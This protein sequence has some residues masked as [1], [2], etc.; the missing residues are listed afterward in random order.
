MKIRGLALENFRKFRAPVRLSGFTDGLN[1]ICEANE[2]GKSTLLEAMRAALFERHGAKSE[3]VRSFRPWGDE[4]APAVELTFELRGEP[5]VIRK[6]FLQA[7]RAVLVGPSGQTFSSD[8]AEERLQALLGFERSGK[9]G[10]DAESR[11]VLGMLWIEQGDALRIMVPGRLA[12]ETIESVLAGE[13]GAVTGG[14]RATAVTLAVEGALKELRTLGTGQ[15]TGR[16]LEAQK[17]LEAARALLTDA[18]AISRSFGESLDRLQTVRGELVRLERDLTA[19]EHATESKR[20]QQDLEIARAA[21]GRL[22][23]AKA[24]L[25]EATSRREG[26]ER[27]LAEREGL[28]REQQAADDAVKA[29]EAAVEDHAPAFQRALAQEADLA[30]ALVDLRADLQRAEADATKAQGAERAT[31]ERL[32]IAKAFERLDGAEGLVERLAALRSELDQGGMSQEQL[33]SPVGFEAKATQA[34]AALQAGAATL[35]IK[36]SPGVEGAVTVGGRPAQSGRISVVTPIMVE[37]AGIGSMTVSPGAAS[38][39]TVETA[40]RRASEDLAAAL[41]KAGVADLARARAVA[42]R[43]RALEADLQA[44]QVRLET[45]CPAGPSARHWVWR[46]SLAGC[47]AGSGAPVRRG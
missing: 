45:A 1:M 44:H 16:L 31:R 24:A 7:P 20:A 33:E 28:R 10:A 41:A 6:R 21:D 42:E 3:Y 38:G 26:A 36:L 25:G 40:Y 32:A 35:D 19:P 18:E 47:P 46:R 12:R 29:A 14:R 13:V 27:K 23:E 15:S 34:Q 37:I 9:G 22:R 11:G 4:T 5:W 8:E 39:V 43:R 30:R 17:R 2:F